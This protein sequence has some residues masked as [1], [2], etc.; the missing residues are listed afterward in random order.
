MKRSFEQKIRDAKGLTVPGKLSGVSGFY[1]SAE[2]GEIYFVEAR[3]KWEDA[4]LVDVKHW[5]EFDGWTIARHYGYYF[6]EREGRVYDK[7][8]VFTS[9]AVIL[10]R[11]RNGQH[12]AVNGMTLSAFYKAHQTG[13]LVLLDRE[14]FERGGAG[15]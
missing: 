1:F 14:I 9:D 13:R 12:N 3:K 10:L 11:N 2:S 5:K 8:A 15:K 7:C 4:V 6:A